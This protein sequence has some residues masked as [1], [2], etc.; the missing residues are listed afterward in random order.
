MN[1]GACHGMSYG[2]IDDKRCKPCDLEANRF[3][4]IKNSFRTDL[5]RSLIYPVSRACLKNVYGYV[6]VC[7]CVFGN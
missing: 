3:V 7:L 6:V 5:T 1:Y 2:V 4:A